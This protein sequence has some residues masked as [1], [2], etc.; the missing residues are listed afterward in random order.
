VSGD[1][2]SKVIITVHGTGDATV[3]DENPKWW[4][5]SS[6]FIARVFKR[7]KAE[8][9]EADV[10][11]YYWGGANSQA[12]RMKSSERFAKKLK[13]D[14]SDKE[15]HIVAHSHG[16]NVVLDALSQL[17][18]VRERIASVLLVGTPRL[19][20]SST[21]TEIAYFAAALYTIVLLFVMSFMAEELFNYCTSQPSLSE[22]ANLIDRLFTKGN[23][24]PCL[25]RDEWFLKRKIILLPLTVILVAVAYIIAR[26]RRLFLYV[27]TLN[28]LAAVGWAGVVYGLPQTGGHTLFND[29]IFQLLIWTTGALLAGALLRRAVDIEI[30]RLF[31][32]PS[33]AQLADRIGQ[34]YHTRDEVFDLLKSVR[35]ARLKIASVAQAGRVTESFFLAGTIFAVAL[36]LIGF[37]VNVTMQSTIAHVAA[38]QMDV[39]QGV[40][41]APSITVAN[42]KTGGMITSINPKLAIMAPFLV[43][44]LTVGLA[45]FLLA[46]LSFSVGAI[47]AQ[48]GSDLVNR[49][50]VNFLA[51]VALGDD[52]AGRVNFEPIESDLVQ[53]IEIPDHIETQMTERATSS[54]DATIRK[55]VANAI[56][57]SG[58]LTNPEVLMLQIS[59]RE[60][61]HCGYF[62]LDFLA[63]VVATQV[64]HGRWIEPP[65]RTAYS[66]GPHR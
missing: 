23:G 54:L 17:G 27:G 14:F 45:Y 13:S 19:K 26:S 52:A 1:I 18:G 7:I 56:L 5:P 20:R 41:V 58:I 47:A 62:E 12:E 53:R 31:W 40:G 42:P 43:V 33:V 22:N 25:I 36:F 30:S 50:F 61:V 55:I 11:S 3:D 6:P 48:P 51:G 10:H 4:Q 37:V 63:D 44:P 2:T 34:V 39:A 57:P 32:R 24:S 21:P 64:V 38:E 66:K 35:G 29:S 49:G 16:G 28:T 59:F 60:F 15:V 9:M 8:G 65:T 46:L